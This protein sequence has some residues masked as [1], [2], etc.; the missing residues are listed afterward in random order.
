MKKTLLHHII[1][2]LVILQFSCATISRN[3]EERM[4]QI[5]SVAIVPVQVIGLGRIHEINNE[6]ST[7][8]IGVEREG[9]ILQRDMYRYFLRHMYYHQVERTFLQDLERTNE[10]L[11]ELEDVSQG[12]TELSVRE[13]CDWL[14][15]D[16]LVTGTTDQ[17]APDKRLV[18]G[19]L[20]GRMD[21]DQ[22]IKIIFSLRNKY[23]QVY[24]SF[25]GESPCTND[26]VYDTSKALI[27]LATSDFFHH[28]ADK[29][30]EKLGSAKMLQIKK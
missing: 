21:S 15:V 16:G 5:K 4:T 8:Q 27:K 23:G 1:L 30:G 22:N 6:I 28:Y 11:L 20:N 7:Q 25:K 26:K 14:G 12:K 13:I 2:L 10:L 18:S 24:W 29:K 19:I 3:D 17:L 9:L